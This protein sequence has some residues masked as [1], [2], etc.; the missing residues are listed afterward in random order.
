MARLRLQQLLLCVGQFAEAGLC[1]LDQLIA[2]I[3][4]TR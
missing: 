4:C 3:R 1:H 2:L